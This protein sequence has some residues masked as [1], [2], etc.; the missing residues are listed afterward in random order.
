MVQEFSDESAAPQEDPPLLFGAELASAICSLGVR[1]QILTGYF[2]EHL[3]RHFQPSSIEESDL[4]RLIWRG[5]DTSAILVKSIF[6]WD[7]RTTEKRPALLVKRNAYRNHRVGIADKLQAPGMDE[8][9]NA[10]FETFWIG[11]HTIFCIAKTGAQAELLGTEVQRELTQMGPIVLSALSLYKYQ[12][13]EVGPIVEI[14]E[15]TED[16]AVP[17]TVIWAYHEAWKL[18]PIAP[19]LRGVKL[20]QLLDAC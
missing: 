4:R 12:V 19:I 7:P 6:E 11:S 15:A 20:E 13:Q 8:Q 3:R 14:E 1:P 10:L 2:I 18:R 5:D 16:F 17:V 9:G